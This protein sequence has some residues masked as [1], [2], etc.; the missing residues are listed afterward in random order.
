MRNLKK[1]KLEESKLKSK[2]NGSKN[3]SNIKEIEN[4]KINETKNTSEKEITTMTVLG[5]EIP[6]DFFDA[7]MKD[8]IPKS[9]DDESDS[10]NDNNNNENNKQHFQIIDSTNN[11]KNTTN[12]EN[13]SNELKNDENIIDKSAILPSDETGYAFHFFFS[14][15]L[16]KPLYFANGVFHV[17]IYDFL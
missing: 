14:L 10:D 2:Q 3:I 13:N 15:S 17:M 6:T 1:Q 9:K 4:N 7:A 5:S 12:N 16:H 11:N 8:R